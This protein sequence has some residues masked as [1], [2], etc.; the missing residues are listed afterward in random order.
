MSAGCDFECM[1]YMDENSI[2]S[3][4]LCHICTKPLKDPVCTPCDHS[5]GRTCITTW[6]EENGKTSCPMCQMDPITTQNLT[7]ISGPLRK[8]LDGIRVRCLSCNE[9][10]LIRGNFKDH[11]EKTCPKANVTCRAADI[12]CPWMGTREELLGHMNTCVFEP[13]RPVLTVLIAENRQL[14]SE[15]QLH[16][17][18]IRKLVLKVRELGG[19]KIS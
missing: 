6:L 4:L 3:N 19:G 8:I 15:V 9:K 2:D 7:G 16:T 12:K 10:D 1:E 11:I 5:F 18:E 13:L 17:E 14:K